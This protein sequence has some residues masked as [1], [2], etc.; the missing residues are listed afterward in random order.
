MRLI[1]T[2][3][4]AVLALSTIGTPTALDTLTDEEI[5]RSMDEA[6]FLSS[7]STTLEVEIVAEEP[8]EV[9]T[10]SLKLML[11]EQDEE[12]FVRIEFQSPEELAGQIFLSVPSGTYFWQPELFEPI[13]TSATQAAFG[14]AAV[15]QISGVR[16]A[17]NYGVASRSSVDNGTL[18]KLE[19]D[20]L[21]SDVAFQSLAVFV[22]PDS[23]RPQELLLY[24]ATD[25]LLYTVIVESYGEL[26]GDLYARS[27]L[28]ENA[29]IE[30]NSTR[31]TI[32]EAR[33]EEL[34]SELFDPDELSD[35]E[36]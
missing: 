4:V 27:Q 6:R 31:L 23:L 8:D 25:A 30:G 33:T 17:G 11:R 1:S 22:D 7:V 35:V 16:F 3:A 5:L 24:S 19:L 12:S 29:L 32:V 14:D 21:R 15:A 10:A 2:M 18:W 36:S 9:R 28:V 13:R 26:Q 20:A 34:P